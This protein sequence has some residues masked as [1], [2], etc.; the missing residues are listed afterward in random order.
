M[1]DRDRLLA[2]LERDKRKWTVRRRISIT[3]FVCLVI[4]LVYYMLIP[5][6]LT[7]D[8]AKYM[9]DFNSIIITLVGAFTGIVMVYIGA[10]TY[11]DKTISMTTG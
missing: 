4:C 7:Q 6:V 5:F 1:T 11:S 9:A 10:A 2:E 8:Q 3:S